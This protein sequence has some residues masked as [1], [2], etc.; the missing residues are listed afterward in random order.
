MRA[1]FPD[2]P[3]I[4]YEGPDSRNPLAFRWYDKQRMIAGKSMGDHFRFAMAYW[5]SFCGNGSDPFG[6]PTRSMPWT[7][8]A[9]DLEIAKNKMDAAFEFMQKLGLDYY[10]FHD[11]DLIDNSADI[12]G[13]QANIGRMAEYAVLKQNETGIRLLWGTANL[14]SH[15]RYMNGAAT[16][17][18]F[19]VVAHAALQVKTAI[20]ATIRLG[21]QN[22]V[23]WGGREGYMSL[24]NTDMKREQEHLARFLTIARDYARAAGFTGTFLIEPKPMEPMKHQYDY[25]AATVLG[26]L[27]KYDLLDDFAL[28]LE[29][30]H[31]TLAGHSMEHEMQVAADAGKLGSMDANRGDYQNGWDTDQF[32]VDPWELTQMML[33]LLR[34][35][36]F[37]TGGI[38][39]DAKIRRNSTDAEDLVIAH[40]TGMDAFARALVTADQIL[41]NSPLADWQKQRYA[42]FDKGDGKDFEEGN[43]TLDRLAALAQLHDQP[44]SSSGKQEKFEQLIQMYL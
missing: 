30:N 36:G 41:S 9:D 10:C 13:Y 22:Y 15:P 27:Q 12:T 18:D 44:G 2:I 26:F 34:S 11:T 39:F 4:Q 21:G 17:P 38:N 35:G 14:F 5:H 42:S 3:N 16:N 8:G 25:D 31:A 37:T 40:I 29:V 24:L 6:Q 1:Y 28:N 7:Q 20:D 19:R 33:I 32:P 23:F 43:I